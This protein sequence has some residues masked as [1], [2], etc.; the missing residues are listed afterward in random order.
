VV[1]LSSQEYEMNA[2]A[3]SLK[4]NT[5]FIDSA[6]PIARFVG[7]ALAV[8]LGLVSLT[9]VLLIP[10]GLVR[11]LV[12][13]GF[14]EL[15]AIIGSLESGLLYTELGFFALTL[16]IGALELLACEVLWAWSRVKALYQAMS[17]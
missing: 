17:G 3:R 5:A 6:A 7:H 10:L 4:T 9:P 13:V 15:S 2:R 16:M 8:A 1:V 14:G 12:M 11:L